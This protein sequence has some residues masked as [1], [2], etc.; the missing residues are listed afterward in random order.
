MLAPIASTP[1]TLREL[2]DV[3]RS[4]PEGGHP[5]THGALLA[6]CARYDL[7]M[8]HGQIDWSGLPTFGGSAPESTDGVWSW[9]ATDLLTG[10]GPDD[11]RIVP[12][13]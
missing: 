6:Y 10:D 2:C 13:A 9:D 1:P 4:A 11:L 5:D 8:R 3:L 7:P 12:R